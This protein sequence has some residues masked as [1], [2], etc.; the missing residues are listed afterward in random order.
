M[1]KDWLRTPQEVL[2]TR[3]QLAV[4]AITTLDSHSQFIASIKM[5]RI[6][7]T[8]DSGSFAEVELTKRDLTTFVETRL[9]T[10]NHRSGSNGNNGNGK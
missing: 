5:N 9:R 10:P 2:E 1:E 6:A 8:R 4:S 7:F 3:F